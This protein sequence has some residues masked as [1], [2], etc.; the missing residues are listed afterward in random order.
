MRFITL[1]ILCPFV[2]LMFVFSLQAPGNSGISDQQDDP[3]ALLVTACHAAQ[4]AVRPRMLTPAAAR[5]PDCS[6]SSYEMRTNPA[7]TA[8]YISGV[9][10]SQNAFGALLRRRWVAILRRTG[11]SH[12]LPEWSVEK[13]SVIGR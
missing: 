3:I 11:A 4:E 7:H 9:V 12:I 2:F 8:V 5:F 13:V 1:Y 10:D 6:D